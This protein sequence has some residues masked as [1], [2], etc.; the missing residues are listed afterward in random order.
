MTELNAPVIHKDRI[1]GIR[2]VLDFSALLC[3]P[4]V[5]F[6]MDGDE[7]IYIGKSL[8]PFARIGAH[9]LE[10]EFDG[11]FVLPVEEKDLSD[12]GGALILH[13]RPRLN[14]GDARKRNDALMYAGGD[15]WRFKD[16]LNSLFGR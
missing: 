14:G 9:V 8:N 4:G 6:L 2:G 10:K 5:Y 16:I 11:V 7:V 1:K 3:G 15:P 12:Y 13:F